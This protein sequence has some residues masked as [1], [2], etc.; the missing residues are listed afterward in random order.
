M[1]LKTSKEEALWTLLFTFY[2]LFTKKT[3]ISFRG[4][5]IHFLPNEKIDLLSIRAYH[6]KTLIN[7]FKEHNFKF[8]KT[9]DNKISDELTKSQF[10]FS[11]INLKD[12]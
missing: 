11:K 1:L 7:F 2:F 4:E 9:N 5:I 12:I 3:I 10:L 8:I 6:S